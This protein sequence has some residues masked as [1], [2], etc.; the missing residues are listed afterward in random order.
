[1]SKETQVRGITCDSAVVLDEFRCA[2]FDTVDYLAMSVV[3]VDEAAD[4]IAVVEIPLPRGAYMI[5]SH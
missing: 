2:E 5:A 4:A 3:A 1:M